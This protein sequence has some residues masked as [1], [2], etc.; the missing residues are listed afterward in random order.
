MCV[1][2]IYINNNNSKCKPFSDVVWW[3]FSKL[4]ALI[5]CISESDDLKIIEVMTTVKE[6]A[7][8]HHQY[9]RIIFTR[10]VFSSSFLFK[11]NILDALYCCVE[12]VKPIHKNIL[13]IELQQEKKPY[14]FLFSILEHCR[15]QSLIIQNIKTI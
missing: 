9:P 4:I 14:E 13:S 8:H 11:G 5:T 6:R 2:W 12:T 1:L 10:P 3:L 15:T 7:F